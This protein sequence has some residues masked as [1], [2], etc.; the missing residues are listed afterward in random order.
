MH[1]P[2]LEYCRIPYMW[3]RTVP[4]ISIFGNTSGVF[5]FDKSHISI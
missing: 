5:V 1:K 4:F 3:N 2:K